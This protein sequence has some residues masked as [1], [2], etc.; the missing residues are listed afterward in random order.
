MVGNLRWFTVPAGF[1]PEEPIIG[2][3]S[4]DITDTAACDDRAERSVYIHDKNTTTWSTV[5]PVCSTV[6]LWW[7][8]KAPQFGGLF[9]SL[10]GFAGYAKASLTPLH[11]HSSFLSLI[12]R[13]TT[14]S[15]QLSSQRSY[16]L[17]QH[18]LPPRINR[19]L[20]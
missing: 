12:F 8:W 20:P 14:P 16:F 5:S 1:L 13:Q 19:S 9:S 18:R 15:V 4:C 6:P 10:G 3:R 2:N 7:V 11:T 17:L